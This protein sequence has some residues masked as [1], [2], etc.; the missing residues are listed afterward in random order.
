MFVPGATKSG[1]LRLDPSILTGPFD[2]NDA[3]VFVLFY[4]F[5][6]LTPSAPT[7]VTDS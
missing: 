5:V 6:Y 2:E 7:V 4:I 3:N 1:F